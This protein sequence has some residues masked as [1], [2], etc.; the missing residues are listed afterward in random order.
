MLNFPESCHYVP[1]SLQHFDQLS[2]H[3]HS[4]FATGKSQ[5]ELRF[6]RDIR[7]MDNWFCS[8]VYRAFWPLTTHSGHKDNKKGSTKKKKN[9]MRI[10]KNFLAAFHRIT[11]KAA[12]KQLLSSHGRLTRAQQHT[13]ETTQTVNKA[14]RSRSNLYSGRCHKAKEPGELLCYILNYTIGNKLG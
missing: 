9:Q 7:V 11:E 14:R 2:V 12:I 6:V 3:G 1:A 10:T 4:G 13:M 5:R 8:S